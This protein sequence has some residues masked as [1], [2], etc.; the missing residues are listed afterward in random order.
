MPSAIKKYNEKMSPRNQGGKKNMKIRP[1]S[2]FGV[3]RDELRRL[4]KLLQAISSTSN[5]SR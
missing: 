5:H 3:P 1:I 4:L 2:V